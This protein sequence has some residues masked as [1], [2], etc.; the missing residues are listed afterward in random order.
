[1]E[2]CL[3]FC[4]QKCAHART[5]LAATGPALLIPCSSTAPQVCRCW[6]GM[7]LGLGEQ[8]AWGCSLGAGR[9]CSAWLPTPIGSTSLCSERR[10][11]PSGSADS[12]E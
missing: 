1:M 7:V 6:Q 9:R 8:Q 2:L 12:V 5:F 4:F 10:E 11:I 3:Y